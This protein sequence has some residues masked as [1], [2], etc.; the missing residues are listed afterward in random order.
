MPDAGFIAS[1]NF[2]GPMTVAA[3]TSGSD[4]EHAGLQVGDT[5][6]ELQG[7]PVAQESRQQLA[8]M[9]PGDLLT[10]K[11]RSRRGAERELKWKI[12]SRQEISYEV[13]D[14]EQVTPEQRA[15]RAAWLKGEAQ[16]GADSRGS[17]TGADTGGL[18]DTR[19]R[20]VR[21]ISNK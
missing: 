13:K 10:M 2:D 12:G 20:N 17:V 3:I 6:I 5:V 16:T 15:R 8:R 9:N 19:N 11:V 4:A 18:A 1:R 21:G 14:L 7:K